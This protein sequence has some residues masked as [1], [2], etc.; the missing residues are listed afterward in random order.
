MDNGLPLPRL[1]FRWEQ[2]NGSWIN[3]VC[4]YGLVL[5]VGEFDIRAEFDNAKDGEL[6]VEIGVTKSTSF[7]GTP[8]IFSDGVDTP[9]RDGAHAQWDSKSLGG[10]PI[11][12]IC[13]N[14][15]TRVDIND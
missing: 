15:V 1:E 4:R 2:V 12:A 8:P 9:F 14:E 5:P 10:L 6:F 3:R 7:A 11:F 13:G